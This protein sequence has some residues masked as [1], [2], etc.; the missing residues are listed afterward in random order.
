M[1]M[2]LD[3]L[4]LVDLYQVNLWEVQL[5]RLM[6]VDLYQV[7]LWEVQLDRMNVDALISDNDRR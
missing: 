3:N 1:D 5:D 7:N 2:E 4:M 6:L